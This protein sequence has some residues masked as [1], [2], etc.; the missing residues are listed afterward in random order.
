MSNVITTVFD[1]KTGV[2]MR[3]RRDISLRI[4]AE[5]CSVEKDSIVIVLRDEGDYVSDFS[6]NRR[7]S[8]EHGQMHIE[9]ICA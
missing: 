5:T 2:T 1:P 8:I 7:Y 9:N 6:G 3:F 4:K